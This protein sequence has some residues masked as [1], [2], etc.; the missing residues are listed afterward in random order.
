MKVKSRRKIFNMSFFEVKTV[1]EDGTE[2]VDY[3]V[4]TVPSLGKAHNDLLGHS[5]HY[6]VESIA[7]YLASKNKT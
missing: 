4:R 2:W 6:N 3:D 5:F 1:D 7:D